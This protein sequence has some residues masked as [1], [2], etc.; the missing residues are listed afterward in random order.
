MIG[1]DATSLDVYLPGFLYRVYPVPLNPLLPLNVPRRSP[2]VN[3]LDSLGSIVSW[4]E[5][6]CIFVYRWKV[7][8][9]DVGSLQGLLKY[10]GKEKK[11]GGLVA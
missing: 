6:Y 10:P 11:G 5:R 8:G 9:K 2:T 1:L 3:S 7:T 4:R